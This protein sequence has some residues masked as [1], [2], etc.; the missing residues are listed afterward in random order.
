[1][2]TMAIAALLAT[3]PA[4]EKSAVLAAAEAWLAAF[5]AG[6]KAAVEALTHPDGMQF[7]ARYLPGQEPIRVRSNRED[8]ANMKPGGP[9]F[10]ERMWSPTV[11]IRADLAQVWAPYSFDIDGKRS[12]CGIDNFTMMRIGGKWVMTN[13]SWTVE[14]PESCTEL[15][16]LKK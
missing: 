2:I 1:M 14:P 15:G 8:M 3:S 7:S 6:D 5:N 11:L 12:H 4:S 13:A 16:E 10:A 9:H